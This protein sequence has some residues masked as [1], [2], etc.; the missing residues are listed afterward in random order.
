MLA[1]EHEGLERAGLLEEEV[2]RRGHRRDILRRTS[3]PLAEQLGAQGYDRRLKALSLIY[4]IEIYVVLK[5]IWG[6]TDREVEALARWMLEAIVT[7]ALRDAGSPPPRPQ[8]GQRAAGTAKTTGPRTRG[9]GSRAGAP[10]R[11]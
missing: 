6:A 10:K 3:A 1:L 8:P 4:G 11:T 5:D 9:P 2:F 7:A